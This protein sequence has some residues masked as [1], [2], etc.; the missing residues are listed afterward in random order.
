M[1]E[2]TEVVTRVSYILFTYLVLALLVE[3][4]V[5]IL[6]AVYNYIELK[7]RWHKYWNQIADRMRHRYNRLYGYASDKQGK[8]RAIL[9]GLLWNVISDEPYKGGKKIISAKLIRLNYVRLGTRI[10]AF[11]IAAVL[12]LILHLDFIEV[13]SALFPD[14]FWLIGF[15]DSSKF[16]RFLL[17]TAAISIGSEPLHKV[18]SGIEKFADKKRKAAG[19]QVQ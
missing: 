6:V 16:I 11:V 14:D 18:I 13:I 9:D 12:V 15:L 5:E 17:T 19:G 4:I 3:R 7:R 8:I 2:T 10:I 1:D